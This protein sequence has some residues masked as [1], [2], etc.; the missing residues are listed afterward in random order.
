MPK[1]FNGFTI[2]EDQVTSGAAMMSLVEGISKLNPRFREVYDRFNLNNVEAD[3]WYPLIDWL[4]ALHEIRKMRGG[5]I[6]ITQ[7]AKL[8]P[9]H[10]NYPPEITSLPRGIAPLEMVVQGWDMVYKMN[11]TGEVGGYKIEAG[12]SSETSWSWTVTECVPFP[13][14][15]GLAV[16]SGFCTRF[17]DS[18]RFEFK[19][20]AN[21]SN[22]GTRDGKYV[23]EIWMKVNEKRA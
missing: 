19:V 14:E 8:I 18:K 15:I 16:G 3:K 10:A 9:E 20:F 12:R 2:T 23:T 5:A 4:D 11:Q 6:A 17:L 21:M 7:V 1:V 22:T 13:A